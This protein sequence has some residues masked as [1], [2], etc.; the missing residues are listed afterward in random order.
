M[1]TALKVINSMKDE[2]VSLIGAMGELFEDLIIL[3]VQ[4]APR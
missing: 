4:A 1:A 3:G 2:V